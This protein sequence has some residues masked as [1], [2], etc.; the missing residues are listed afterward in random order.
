MYLMISTRHDLSWKTTPREATKWILWYLIW[1]KYAKLNYQRTT[2][3]KLELIGYLDSDCAGDSDKRRSLTGYVFLYGT[4]LI[5]WKATLQSITALSINEAEYIA[6]AK[7]IKEGLWLK[8]LMKGFG[9]KQSIEKIFCDNQSVIHL[10]KNPQYHSRTKH[11]HKVSF[12]TRKDWSWRNTSVESSY[13]WECR[14]YAHQVGLNIEALEVLRVDRFR[15]T[16]KRIDQKK[17]SK[18]EGLQTHFKLDSRWRL[19]IN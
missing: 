8:R 11:K 10:S 15:P 9:I 5:S 2:K 14:W 16:W 6:L 19:K 13:L 1:S 17:K 4:N 7:A 12:R 18:V 3:S